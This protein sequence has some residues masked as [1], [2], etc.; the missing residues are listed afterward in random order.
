MPESDDPPLPQ[1]CLRCHAGAMTTNNAAVHVRELR[2][3]YGQK[4]AVDGVSFDIAPRRDLRPARPERRRQVDD[5]RDPRGLP[6]PHRRRGERARHRPRAAAASTGRRASASCCSRPARPATSTVREQLTHF[7]GFYPNPRD[8]DEVIAAVGLEQK[9]KTRIAQALG[10][11]APPCR[12]RARHHRP[13]R[14]A[15]PRR[16]HDGLRPRGAAPVLGAHP[17]AQGRGHDDPAHHPLPRRG[18]PARRPRRRHRRRPARRHRRASTSSA[19]P[20]R[21]CRSCAGASD[22]A[23]R[24]ERTDEPGRRRGIRRR[25]SAA[26]NPTASRSSGRASRTSTCELVGDEPSTSAR[27]TETPQ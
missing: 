3:E 20:R 21:A 7:A 26:A 6:R 4:N 22:G 24:E 8:V 23:L 25:G 16:A 27:A 5:D 11:A 19:A 9:A 12:R 18:R 15:V 13:A 1:R 17:R 14:A 10:R 2:K